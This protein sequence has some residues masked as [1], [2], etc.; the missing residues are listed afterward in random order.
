MVGDG[1]ARRRLG[2]AL[3]QI[4]K[5]LP[6][7]TVEPPATIAAAMEEVRE[8]RPVRRLFMTSAIQPQRQR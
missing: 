1:A 3:Q 4:A 5:M 7:A 6:A 2:S 8:E